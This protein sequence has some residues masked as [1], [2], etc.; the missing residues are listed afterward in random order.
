MLAGALAHLLA[1]QGDAIGLAAYAGDLRAYLPC[2]PGRSHLRAILIALAKL[3]AS[4]A[5]PSTAA[6]RRTVDLMRGRGVVILISDLYDDED[7]VA[8]ELRRAA[9]MGH[10]I[11][12]FHVLAREEREWTWRGEVEA[13]DSETG[14]RVVVSPAAAQAYQDRVEAFIARWRERCQAEGLLYVPAHVETPPAAVLRA[15]LLR[16]SGGVLR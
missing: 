9:R 16:R 8:R 12:V 3:T 10:D 7:G 13:I 6:L 5:L 14:A 11:T 1:G 15:Y 2:R 4:G